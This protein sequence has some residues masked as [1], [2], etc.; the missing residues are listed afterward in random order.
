[1]PVD[2]ARLKA[3][4]QAETDRFRAD[5]RESRARFA[6]ACGSLLGGVPMTWMVKWAGGHPLFAARARGAAIEDVDGH[7]Y[8]DFALG[9]TGAMAGHSPPPVVDAVARRLGELGGAT[10]DAA[11]PRTRP[12]SARSW[13]G[14]SACRCGASR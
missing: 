3:V 13:R 10:R 11:R 6:Q 8:V 14:A 2:R 4:L 1:M 9:D 5:H 12:G 7:R